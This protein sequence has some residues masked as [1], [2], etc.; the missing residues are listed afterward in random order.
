MEVWEPKFSAAYFIREYGFNFAN[1]HRPGCLLSS[2]TIFP[3]FSKLNHIGF[4]YRNGHHFH[5]LNF[6]A[7]PCCLG[8]HVRFIRPP[9][10]GFLRTFVLPDTSSAVSAPCWYNKWVSWR[11]CS[12]MRSY[13]P[14]RAPKTSTLF[15]ARSHRPDSA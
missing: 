12:S 1:L 2:S 6:P 11:S 8:L 9:V 15:P 3:V 10:L 4:L 13:I 14:S 7:S 5:L